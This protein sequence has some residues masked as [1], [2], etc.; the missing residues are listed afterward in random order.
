MN[1]RKLLFLSTDDAANRS[2]QPLLLKKGLNVLF[3]RDLSDLMKE[4]MDSKDSLVFIDIDTVAIGNRDLKV[5]K[6]SFPE[7]NLFCISKVPFHPE[8]KEA[9]SKYIFA[10]MV[11]P[12]DL[13][14]LMFWVGSLESTTTSIG[15]PGKDFP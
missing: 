8:I 15:L 12:L 10:C 13:E 14:E 1:K 4:L 2:I 5:L 7:S 6:T 9:I 11:K 3:F